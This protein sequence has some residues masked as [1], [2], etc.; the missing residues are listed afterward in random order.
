R[1]AMGGATLKTRFRWRSKLQINRA[2]VR[3][4]RP[5]QLGI[6]AKPA[7]KGPRGNIAGGASV[8]GDM[9]ANRP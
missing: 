3:K 5:W 4:N 7:Q 2:S 6:N 9:Y 8:T 1:Q